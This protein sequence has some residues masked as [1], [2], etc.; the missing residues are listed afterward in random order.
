[1]GKPHEFRSFDA[2]TPTG[3]GGPVEVNRN[4]PAHSARW[5]ALFTT[6]KQQ[7]ALLKRRRR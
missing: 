6:R 5:R 4:V 1:M 2:F 7:R 3:D